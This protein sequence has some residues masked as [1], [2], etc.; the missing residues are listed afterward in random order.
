MQAT[1][2]H[3]AMPKKKQKSESRKHT[4]MLRIDA[5]A[6]EQAKVAAGMMKLTLAEWASDVILKAAERD[7]NREARKIVEGKEKH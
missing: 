1:A 5:H 6:L 2:E 7:M 3:D 4:G